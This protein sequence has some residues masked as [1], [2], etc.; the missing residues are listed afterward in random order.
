MAGLYL[1][2]PFCKQACHYCDFHFSTDQNS[3][4]SLCG[5]MV[6]E[7]QLQKRYVNESLKTIYFGG[8][9]PSLLSLKELG[10]L[11][12][13]IHKTYSVASGAEITLE[14]NPDDLSL[15]KLR[16]LKLSGI[17]RLSIG[18]QSF[19]NDILKF[20]NRA[21]DS[22]T[23]ETCLLQARDIGF[24]NISLD[25]IYAIP[26]LTENRWEETLA[27][28][29]SFSPEHI[30]SYALT[31]E[32]RTVFGNWSK[33]GK[34]HPMEEEPAARQFEILMDTLENSGYE[35]YE[36]S[37]FC[38]PEFYSQHNS[39]YWRG[40]PYL[41]IGPS[42]HSYNGHSRQFNVRNNAAYVRSIDIGKVPSETELLTSE[43]KINEYIL[44]TLR[45]VWGC[46]LNILKTKLNDDLLER[47]G[48]YLSMMQNEELISISGDILTL[49]RKGKL[50]ADK[51]AE[52]LIVEI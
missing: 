19:D 10:G 27:R 44:T 37:N 22:D 49:T 23:A 40:A 25:L 14:A 42:A 26:G 30:S 9:T 33:R 4:S 41:G 36:I 18:I 47:K 28:A 20:L 32:A 6:Q 43:N 34:L 5:A 8:G 12:D 50:L 15:E 45:T 17:N 46:D 29:L 51:I 48:E 39:N 3:I 13:A 16:E 2:V 7:L 1:H 11:L 35:Q 21:H 24:R 38:K 31:I 52:D